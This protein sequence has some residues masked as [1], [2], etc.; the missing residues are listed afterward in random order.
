MVDEGLLNLTH[1]KTPNAEK[2]FYAKQSIGVQTADMYD[3]VIGAIWGDVNQRFAIGGDGS[4]AR[5]Q[6]IPVKAKRFDLVSL[7]RG[8]LSVRAGQSLSVPFEMP[9]YNGSVRVMVIATNKAIRIRRQ[10]QGT[11]CEENIA[12]NIDIIAS[13]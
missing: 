3:Q 12:T 7:F 4:E 10:H 8:P 1:F 13:S 5:K 9:N 6:V 11:I 2:F